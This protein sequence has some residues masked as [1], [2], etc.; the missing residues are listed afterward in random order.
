MPSINN[1]YPNKWLTASDL[2]EEGQVFTILDVSLEKMTDGVEKPVIHFSDEDKGLVC[3]KT[4]AKTL[5]KLLGDDT[6]DWENQKITLYPTEVDFKGERVDA[7]RVR[8]KKPKAAKA[9]AAMV[10]AN[11]KKAAAPMTQ[12]EVD[13][14]GFDDITSDTP[15]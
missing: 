6:D 12:A 1:F 8:N 5:A 2:P 13:D 14:L 4:N 10:P 3:N 11:S 15:F 7:I 9:P